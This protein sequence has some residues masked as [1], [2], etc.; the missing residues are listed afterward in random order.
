M[1]N[2]SIGFLMLGSLPV[3]AQTAEDVQLNCRIEPYVVVE[4][5]SPVEGVISEILVDKNDLV[6]KGDVLARLDAKL[7][8]ATAEL[9]RVQAELS[10]DVDAQQLALDFSQR[11]LE[12]VTN[13]YKTKAASF[14]ELDKVKTENAIAAQQLRQAQ[15]RKRQAELEYQRALADLERRTIVSSIDG[16]VIDRL[17]EPGEHIDYDPVLKLAQLDPLRVEVFAPANL[18]GAIKEGMRA[19]V[20][21][22]LALGKESYYAEVI[23]VD[24]VID[25]PSNTFGVRLSIANANNQLP[26]G[27]KC[28]VKFSG[29]S[30]VKNLLNNT[31]GL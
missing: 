20:I 9:R 19:L 16:V 14:S 22:E 31:S 17:K 6:K 11:S 30:A 3:F 13:L 4:V 26:S 12:R 7:E 8:F 1:R 28:T 21:P 24:K 10:S 5:S 18:Y 27:L 25:A 15:D 29:V 23:H 2:I